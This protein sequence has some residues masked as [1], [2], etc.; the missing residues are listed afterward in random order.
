MWTTGVKLCIDLDVISVDMVLEPMIVQN[1]LNWS[2]VHSEALRANDRSLG[3][4]KLR[5]STSELTLLTLT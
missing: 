3:N 5:S 4:T 1:I 2:D